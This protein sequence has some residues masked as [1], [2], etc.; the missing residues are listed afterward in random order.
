M[1]GVWATYLELLLFTKAL[2][3]NLIEVASTVRVIALFFMPWRRGAVTWLTLL[4]DIRLFRHVGCWMWYSCWL[5]LTRRCKLLFGRSDED[6]EGLKIVETGQDVETTNGNSEKENAIQSAVDSWRARHA[7]HARLVRVA[8]PMRRFAR[9]G[10]VYV[11]T[12]SPVV[13]GRIH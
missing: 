12:H 4:V 2:H 10:P 8:C 9:S 5:R 3:I 7:R 6:I 11:Y 1:L 13:Q